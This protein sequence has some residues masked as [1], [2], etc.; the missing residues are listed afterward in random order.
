M[1]SVASAMRIPGNDVRSISR[2][3]S[4]QGV[5]YANSE[6]SVL[7]AK[8]ILTSS[9]SG[10]IFQINISNSLGH[11]SANAMSRNWPAR[12]S[13]SWADAPGGIRC[14]KGLSG[15]SAAAKSNAERSP[16]TTTCPARSVLRRVLCIMQ[17][18]LAKR[19]NSIRSPG[20]NRGDVVG[21]AVAIAI[22]IRNLWIDR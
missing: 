19:R 18:R 9:H 4:F 13:R 21:I 17:K 12:S 7:R 3:R 2:T 20:L 22:G 1:G 14:S 15:G 11:N 6:E 5:A 16:N 8:T 10:R